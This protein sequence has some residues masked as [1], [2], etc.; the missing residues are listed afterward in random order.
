MVTAAWIAAIG[1]VAAFLAT[2]LVIW[3]DHRLRVEER[4]EILW[5]E[6]QRV[7]ITAGPGRDDSIP[8]KQGT[9]VGVTLANNSRRPITNVRVHAVTAVGNNLGTKTKQFIGAGGRFA[10]FQFPTTD[11]LWL[12]VDGIQQFNAY[13]AVAFTDHSNH[14]WL[15]DTDGKVDHITPLSEW[16]RKLGLRNVRLRRSESHVA[17]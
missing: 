15:S 1:T 16:W 13:A 8:G 12:M 4:W 10:V 5:D 17:R 2:S 7:E 11:D 3:R 9:A 6:A 14:L